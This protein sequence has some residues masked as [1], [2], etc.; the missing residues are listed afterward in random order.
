MVN[1]WSKMA[2]NGVL[3]IIR[4]LYCGW[5]ECMGVSTNGGYP[6]QLDSVKKNIE[7]PKMKWMIT[8]G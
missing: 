1:R 2:F 8:G 7:T 4:P 5:M 6:K 3:M